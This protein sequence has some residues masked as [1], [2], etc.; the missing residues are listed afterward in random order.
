MQVLAITVR[1]P[2][3]GVRLH[4]CILKRFNSM[5]YILILLVVGCT[6]N[7]IGCGGDPVAE[8]MAEANSNNQKRLANLYAMFRAEHAFRGP[9][10]EAEFKSFLQEKLTSE[11]KERMQISGPI[12]NV[13]VN[14]R[15]GK[16]FKI[17][18]GVS[19]GPRGGNT[20]PIIFEAEGKDGVRIVSFSSV[21]Q[22][23]VSD[24]TRYQ[25]LWNMEAS[26]FD[27]GRNI[28]IPNSNK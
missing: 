24:E 4:V 1:T 26:G 8:M 23:N 3:M 27:A 21:K 14:E 13:F 10:D 25:E 5:R 22:E 16:P 2:E 28:S 15:D 9:D 20:I 19:G 11:Q 7:S 18:Y 12:D 17:R 6:I